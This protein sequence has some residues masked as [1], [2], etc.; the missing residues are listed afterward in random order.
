MTVH[1]VVIVGCGFG[2]LFAAKG[3]RRAPVEL[4]VVD[5]RNHHLFQPLLYQMSTGI[6]S[7]GDI[8]P[9]IRGVLRR[10]ANATVLLGDVEAIDLA[11]RSLRVRAP[12]G[13]IEVGYDS[14]IVAAGAQQS[15]FGHPEFERFAP[16]MKSIED[17][18]LLRA[19][20]FGAFEAAEAEP[21]PQRRRRWLTFVVVG[22]GATGVEMAGQIVELSRRP[23][24]GNF[25]RIDPA[26][27]RVV[28]LDA[29][30]TVLAAFPERLQAKS[31]RALERLGVEL[32]LNAPVTG[33]DAE[34]V[35]VAS[36]DPAVR[37][38]DAR[39]R[40]WC[41]GV[42]ASPLGAM[43][44][45]QS[46]ATVDRAGRIEVLPDCTLPG[47]PEVFVVGD[48]MSLD[49]L[50]GVAEVAMQC[51]RHVSKTIR[52]RLGGDGEARPFRY[53]DLGTM[54]T[55]SRFKG[56]AAIG[57]FRTVGFTG[58]VLWLVVH[59]LFLTGFKN[60]V[61]TLANWTIAFLG[62]GRPQRVMSMDEL[63]RATPRTPEEPSE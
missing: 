63:D 8:A 55:I 22:A 1:R 33:V 18:H 2:G 16:G 52:R 49:G 35:D 42:E 7:E 43:L 46:G 24:R 60:R 27:T 20:I 28:L 23:L 58:W 21:D 6:L 11:A 50:P 10:Q 61:F 3:L 44:G 34:G 48:M 17:A 57:R 38:I 31:A 30:P 59:L 47:H 25:R 40:I 36:D 53:R 15:Y 13:M 12:D 39:T 26:E 51:G 29:G 56:V 37:R 14:L 5:R 54:A 62:S 41:A 19:R 4:T 32:H 9:P 45:E